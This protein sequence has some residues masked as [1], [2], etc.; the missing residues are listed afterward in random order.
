MKTQAP[1]LHR[2][3]QNLKLHK[4]WIVIALLGLF[5]TQA[6]ASI[7]YLSVTFDEP[8]HI[9]TGYS[10]LC[11]GDFRLVEDHPP[12]L[13]MW[14][15]L[16]LIFSPQIPSPSNIPT[17][18]RGDRRL[19]AHHDTWW[20]LPIDMWLTPAR[21]MIVLLG[22]ILAAFVYRWATDAFGILSGLFAIS[23]YT[24]DPNILAHTRLATLDIGVTALTVIA[25]Y[26]AQRIF[27]KNN[28]FNIT[29]AGICLGLALTAKISAI[30]LIPITAG[31]LLL[32]HI[33][34]RNYQAIL[35]KGLIYYS[36]TFMTMW[37]VHLFKVGQLGPLPFKVPFP[38][39]WQSL[40]R[41][42]THIV[43]EDRRA[44]LLGHTYVGG[45]WLYFPVVFLL[46]TPLPT[47]ILLSTTGVRLFKKPRHV[48]NFLLFMGF[49]IVY[50]VISLNSA[51]NIGYR[52]LLPIMPFLHIWIAHLPQDILSILP[53]TNLQHKTRL[54]LVMLL[55]IG[56]QVIGTLNVWP[57]HLTY[58]NTLAGGPSKGHHY[59][60]DSNVDWGQALK[61]VKTYIAKHNLSHA[62]LS[63]FTY[64]L[65]P[66]RVYGIQA[67]PLPPA[68]NAP[69][70]LPQ[71][72]APEPGVY[73][74]SA[75]TLRGLQVVDAEMYNWFW[76]RA[77]DDIIGNA[78]LVYSIHA[79]IPQPNWI[80]QCNKPVIPLST[81]AL[82]EGF[83][84]TKY[85]L[86]SFNCSQSWIYPQGHHTAGWYVLHRE[87]VEQQSPFIQDHLA[88]TTLSF[89]KKLPGKTPPLS[90]FQTHPSNLSS[91]TT[92]PL[93]IAP[94]D[95][96][97][98]QVMIQGNEQFAPIALQGP[99]IFTG[100]AIAQN[101]T[102]IRL[103][104]FWRVAQT[105]TPSFSLMAHMI[106]SSGIPVAVGDGLGMPWDQVE[107][108]DIIVQN[109]VMDL[110][111]D[112]FPGI[113]WIQTGAYRL[114]TMTRFPILN[115]QGPAGDRI[116]LPSLE[117][118]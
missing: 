53:S 40:L 61:A 58:F 113:Y 56:W 39:Y 89:E 32:W 117:I 84:P 111:S 19:F 4:R 34:Q 49:P 106:D 80:A 88:L 85:R 44:F 107:I 33:S 30:L 83:G 99:V 69:P 79:P 108:G 74:I 77:P 25:L 87:I 37:A 3:T 11:T 67:D 93:W 52:H 91:Q 43:T 24:F 118:E 35:K 86:I 103:Q 72:Y 112:L 75:S 2:L 78:M 110:P 46:K 15:S 64:Y 115:E 102:E 98:S 47:L 38:T 13:E 57:Y 41:I 60:A 65:Q 82:Q 114:D 22:V 104:T 97:P 96:R 6:M 51:I 94:T 26:L 55:L 105:T 73:I 7:P 27:K 36:A 109:H 116:L 10:I 81:Q 5:F 70:L 9:T 48:W 20:Q 101:T 14:M 68:M 95:W 8:V 21:V 1:K 71:S 63:H 45:H 23:L 92:G 62:R 17:W 29:I 12:L 76:H 90:I 59:L 54:S 42:G 28:E 100:Y 18:E 31:L 50:L 16:P 66:E